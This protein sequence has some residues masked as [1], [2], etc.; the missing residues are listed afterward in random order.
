MA[1]ALSGMAGLLR[2]QRRFEDAERMYRQA[3]EVLENERGFMD[4]DLAAV[5]YNLGRLFMDQ[6]RY[7]DA[8]L[9]FEQSLDMYAQTIGEN[10]ASVARVLDSYSDLL[11]RTQRANKGRFLSGMA[12]QIRAEL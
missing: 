5:L 9:L 4:P 8:E 10:N 12:A 6:D 7:D 3:I 11:H 2:E 1:G